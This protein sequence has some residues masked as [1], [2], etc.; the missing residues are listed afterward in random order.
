MNQ[1]FPSK[2]FPLT[3]P[4][5]SWGHPVEQCYRDFPVAKKFMDKGG[6]IS[7]LCVEKIFTHSAEK[8]R[9]GVL[10]CFTNFRYRNMLGIKEGGSIKIFRRKSFVSWCR[11]FRT[12][13]LLCSV[14]EISQERRTLW[15]VGGGFQDFP[16]KNFCL[17]VANIS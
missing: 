14:S 2:F 10:F 5:I 15:I 11:I 17:M 6:G 9:K 4:K 1:D 13:T 12:A 3:L 8:L 7:R 16:S